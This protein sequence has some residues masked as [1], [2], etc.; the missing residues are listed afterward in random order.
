MHG[1]GTDIRLAARRLAATPQF[2]V[3]AAL[4]LAVGVGVT[5]AV[6][7]ILYSVFWRPIPVADPS[8][9]VI[10]AAPGGG[11]RPLMPAAMSDPDFTDVQ[12]SQHTMSAVAAAHFIGLPLVAASTTQ[13]IEGEAVSADYFRV[14][15]V[16]AQVGRVIGRDDDATAASVMVISDRT[17]RTRF[18]R[19]PRVIGRTVRMGGH[20]FEIIGVARDGFEGIQRGIARAGVWIPLSTAATIAGPKPA[21]GAPPRTRLLVVGRLAEGRRPS[22]AASELAAIAKRLDEARPMRLTRY[23]SRGDTSYVAKRTWSARAANDLGVTADQRV[24]M[25]VVLLVALVLGVACTN[26]A[27]LMLA[28][29]ALRQ[30]EFAV[31]RALGASRWRLVREVCIEGALVAMAGGVAAVAL[32]AALLRAASI[33][34]PLPRGVFSLDPEL[35][36][37]AL[38]AACVALGLSMLVF[39]LEPALQLTRKNVTVDFAGGAAAVGVPRSRRQQ[40][41]IR[42]QVAVSAGFFLVAAVLVRIVAL[43]ATND[44]GV[45]VD[46]LSLAT[47]HFSAQRMDNAR[48]RQT[49]DEITVQL[50][51]MPGIES[52]AVASGTPFGMTMTPYA[53]LTTPDRPFVQGVRYQDAY[54]IAST[55]E[56]FKTLGVPIVTGRGF[57]WRDD[58]AAPRVMVISERTARSLFGAVNA[59]GRQLSIQV[60]GRP[61]VETFTVVGIARETDTGEATR[62][63]DNVIYFPLA[64]HFEPNVAIIARTSGDTWDGAR[65]IQSAVRRVDPDLGTGTVGPGTLILAGEFFA[66]RIAASFASALGLLT[67]AMSMIGLYGIQSHLVARR[68]REVGL[69][70]AIGAS[71]AQIERMILGEGYRPV[72][73]GLALGLFLGVFV[74]LLLRAKVNGAIEV[75]DPLAFAVIP[76]PLIAAAFVACYLPARRASR[77]DPNEALRHL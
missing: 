39:G 11:G 75:F 63:N 27:N 31:R 33:D 23:G 72:V 58:A 76:I 60:W 20:P 6:Y 21:P 49:L 42:W 4:S 3:F 37:P 1:L 48:A 77:I 30:Q 24:A 47:M 12:A 2:F 17:W 62:R 5:T 28:R 61:P 25:M 52:V 67:L 43:E 70:M 19:D 14:V 16:G 8:S 69:R 44:T 41:F 71:A 10:V 50:R 36:V 53:L 73:Q 26:L 74:R 38:I 46:R 56:I 45:D 34:I 55:P 51:Q 22:D 9:V 13:F 59:V 66:A 18:D 35:N 40:A 7:S 29:G 65:A 15:G 64:Q 54:A 57:D 68:T 32:L